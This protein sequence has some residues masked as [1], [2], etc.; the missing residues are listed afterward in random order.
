MTTGSKGASGNQMSEDISLLEVENLR[1]HFF[2]DRGVVKAVNGAWLKV[3]KGE[4]LGLAGESGCGKT[5]VAHSIM[6]LIPDPGQIVDGSI[7]YD[8]RD[9]VVLSEEEMRRTRWKEISM[10]FQSAM[11]ALNPV[12]RVGDQIADAVRF[13]KSLSKRDAIRTAERLF[14]EVGLAK[15]RLDNY[16]F[17][18][19]G[20]M[21]QRAI[22]ALALSCEPRL[23]IADEPVTALDVTIQSQI[24]SLITE[25]RRRHQTSII[26]IS[27]DLSVISET[28]DKVAVMYAG[29]TIEYGD[30][31][32]VYSKPIHP[33]TKGL[34]D[35]IPNM[36]RGKAKTLFSI[37]GQPPDLVEP[38]TGCA[39]HLRCPYEKPVCKER[40]PERRR[41]E[42]R[43]VEC[44]FAE[45]LIDIQVTALYNATKQPMRR[46]T[47]VSDPIVQASNLRKL[48][49]IRTGLVTGAFSKRR[50]YLHAVDD[51]SFDIRRGEIFGLVGESGCGKTTLGRCL[52]KRYEPTSGRIVVNDTDLG[53]LKKSGLKTYRRNIQM[54]FQDPYE[55]LDPRQSV[56]DAVAE[57]LK[58]HGLTEDREQERKRV[59]ELLELLRLIPPQDYIDKFPHQ[60][61]GGERQRVVIARAMALSPKIIVADEPVSML[62]VSVRAGVLDILL[63]LRETY[64]VTILFITHD[65][66]VASYM[67]D[68]LAVMYLGEIVEI[69]P[70]E[71]IVNEPLHPYTQALMASVPSSDPLRKRRK[72][73]ARGE[74]PNPANPPTGCRFHP[75]CQH[76]MPVCCT[77]KP[78]PVAYE[79]DRFVACFLHTPA[80]S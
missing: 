72:V 57:P 59:A 4:A 50:D 6:R 36:E 38:P 22:I 1:T 46:E 26:L 5:T 68:R 44:H 19:S 21:K 31:R 60:L 52:V 67:T 25:L 33:Y 80:A 53:L 14:E 30:V 23:V 78:T 27:H 61:S 8:G 69:G 71:I 75:R 42:G 55:A 28:C 63:Q 7:R 73:L 37:P 40:R 15:E 32:S 43:W 76:A 62:D 45:E 47:K 66:A 70:T 51:V 9:L 29:R 58:V 41:V 56:Y 54:I 20:G 24:L 10:V 2:T 74:P 49:Q 79:N 13:H 18:F 39:F 77:K 17:E 64:E 3:A 11:N 48:F 16:P 65:L 35:A 12:M 34:I